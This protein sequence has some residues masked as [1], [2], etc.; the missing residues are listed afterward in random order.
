MNKL[1]HSN[2]QQKKAGFLLEINL[3]E[4]IEYDRSAWFGGLGI[5]IQPDGSTSLIGNLEDQSALF[6]VLENINKLGVTIL[7]IES[8]NI[9]IKENL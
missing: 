7:S 6:G 9:N 4:K 8:K 3:Q 2:F 5:Q 1:Q